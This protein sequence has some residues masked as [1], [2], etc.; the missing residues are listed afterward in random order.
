MLYILALLSMCFAVSTVE[1]AEASTVE[2][3]TVST[4]EQCSNIL[5]KDFVIQE[6]KS[7]DKDCMKDLFDASPDINSYTGIQYNSKEFYISVGHYTLYV[8][9]Y[10]KTGKIVGFLI[11]EN[12]SEYFY[13]RAL[14]VDKD[15]RRFGI[16]TKLLTAA[17]EFAQKNNY[18]SMTIS[19]SNNIAKK[20][21]E[22]FGFITNSSTGLLTINFHQV[23]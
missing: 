18:P 1:Q 15:Y 2:Q 20:C 9:K 11:G 3:I 6:M 22:K 4:A 14:G 17:Y 23:I 10:V 13:V 7:E 16:A 21:Y 12:F 8:C 19:A 5:A